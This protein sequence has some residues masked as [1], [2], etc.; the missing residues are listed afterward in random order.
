MKTMTTNE[1][2]AEATSEEAII[3]LVQNLDALGTS[4]WDCWFFKAVGFCCPIH[5][6]PEEKKAANLEASRR[7]L[8]AHAWMERTN[9]D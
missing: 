2:S 8:T 5:G 7:L 6:T 3:K 1:T 9:G 4:C